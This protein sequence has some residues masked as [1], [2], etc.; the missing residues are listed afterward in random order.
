M[1]TKWQ[2]TITIEVIVDTPVS[3]VWESWTN[4]KHIV[5]WNNASSD[6]HTPRA[7][8][9]LRVWWKFLSRMEA[10]DGSF[11]FDFG[12][13]YDKIKVNELISYK[14]WDGRQVIIEFE[15]DGDKTKIVETF[16]IEHENSP[17]LQR[18]WWQ[19]ILNNFK[20]YTE[21]L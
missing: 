13:V 5:N 16:E 7:E 12:W 9:D 8:N 1:K 4:P 2:N 15:K 20:K 21:S 3:K 10:I 6:W 11:G 17:E 19:S 14:I 18:T